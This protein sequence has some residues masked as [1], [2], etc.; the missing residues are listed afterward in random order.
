M[1]EEIFQQRTDLTALNEAVM[2]IRGELRKIII[3]QDEMV[4]LIIAALLAEGHILIEGV[5]G[6]A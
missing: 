3:G 2:A 5:P 1:E 4:K 6:V